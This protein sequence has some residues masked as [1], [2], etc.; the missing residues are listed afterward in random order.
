MSEERASGRPAI[1]IIEDS[2]ISM[3]LVT[4]LLRA[5][6]Y[7]VLPA[8]DA[9]TGI[10]LAMEEK[11]VLILMDLSL[12]GTDGWSAIA[13][14]KDEAETR[15]IPVVALAGHATKEDEERA[16]AAGCVGYI[17]KPIDTR[18]FPALVDQFIR[19]AGPNA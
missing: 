5:E 12:P 13:G 15:D 9:E 19:A 4:V 2:P 8:A 7:A 17:S 14:L 10:A 18:A 6:G 11:P 1:L 16:L 3:E